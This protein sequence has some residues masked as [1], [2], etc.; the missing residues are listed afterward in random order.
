M[1]GD[2]RAYGGGDV[3]LIDLTCPW[4][5][6]HL[7]DADSVRPEELIRQTEP[8]IAGDQKHAKTARNLVGALKREKQSRALQVIIPAPDRG[9]A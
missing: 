3:A 1:R 2:L 6:R 8:S 9:P 4:S 7:V 5:Y